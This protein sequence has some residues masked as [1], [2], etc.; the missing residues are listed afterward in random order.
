MLLSGHPSNAAI[1]LVDSEGA[2]EGFRL[3]IVE[4]TPE[5]FSPV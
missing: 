3:T 4:A 5:V 1:S 2:Q